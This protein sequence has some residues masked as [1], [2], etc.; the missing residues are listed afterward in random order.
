M[1]IVLLDHVFQIL[2]PP[3]F[4]IGHIVVFGLMHGPG[5][6]ILIHH[7]HAQTVA[8][9]QHGFGAGVMGTPEGIV[10]ILL[11]DPYFTFLCLRESAGAKRAIIMMDTGAAKD[12]SLSVDGHTLPGIPRKGTDTEGLF[13]HILSELHAGRVQMRMIRAPELCPRDIQKE[14]CF[15]GVCEIFLF[16]QDLLSVQDLQG[17]LSG[18]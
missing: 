2:L 3:V 11:M 15:R 8:G 13:C 12:H 10:A 16:R 17:N 9:I 1:I 14:D 6:Y 18:S 4:E 7:Q 5:I